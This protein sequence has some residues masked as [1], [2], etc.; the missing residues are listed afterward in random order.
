V[1][2]LQFFKIFRGQPKLAHLLRVLINASEDIIHFILVFLVIFLNFAFSGYMIYGLFLE[3]WSTPPRSINSAFR[4]LMG[5]TDLM[6]MYTYAPVSTVL[7]FSLFAFSLI[8]VMLNLLLAITFDH[9]EMVKDNEGS[10]TGMFLQLKFLL[11][12]LVDRNDGK[13]LRCLCC[14]CR[15]S[16]VPSHK[17]ILKALAQGEGMSDQ[18]FLST[19][20]WVTGPKTSWKKHAHRVSV[21]TELAE[22]FKK[23]QEDAMPDLRKVCDDEDYLESLKLGCLAYTARE[24][25]PQEAKLNLLRELVSIAEAD[26]EAMRIRLGQCGQRSKKTMKRFSTRIDTVEELVHASL[27]EIVSLAEHAGVPTGAVPTKSPAT[28]AK[29][30]STMSSLRSLSGTAK[31]KALLSSSLKPVLEALGGQPDARKKMGST[32]PQTSVQSWYAADRFIDSHHKRA[33]PEGASRHGN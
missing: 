32:I 33:G 16:S 25:T 26:I 17:A 24:S 28:K 13:W 15:R 3:S 4:A 29:L 20:Q 23:T 30:D 18:E 14:C 8:F 21:Q 9:Y 19:Q 27:A 1:L 22:S 2:T 12:D 7:W 10:V 31:S 6:E 5:D 11:Q